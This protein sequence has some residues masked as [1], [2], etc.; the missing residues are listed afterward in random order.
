MNCPIW[1]TFSFSADIAKEIWDFLAAKAIWRALRA[2]TRYSLADIMVTALNYLALSPNFQ[3]GDL[4]RRQQDL[5]QK[6]AQ[7]TNFAGNLQNP[8]RT[9]GR[10]V[11]GMCRFFVVLLAFFYF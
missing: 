8:R 11:A 3:P 4:A 7:K 2:H 6:I 1:L 9:P 10:R 5:C